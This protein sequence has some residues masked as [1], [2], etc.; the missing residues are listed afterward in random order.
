MD[1]RTGEIVEM[2]YVDE[3]KSKGNPSAKFY[4][5]IPDIMMG[6]I[7]EMNRQQRR[8]WYRENKKRIKEQTNGHKTV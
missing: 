7:W 5:E 6:E 4:K 8:E 3:L 1:T 2:T